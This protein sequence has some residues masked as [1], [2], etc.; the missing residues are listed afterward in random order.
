MDGWRDPL[1]AL[2]AYETWLARQPLSS[3]TRG[4]YVRWVRLFCGWLADGAD[5]RALGADPLVDLAARDYAAR[6]FKRFLKSE[7]ALGPASVNL[8][9][10]AVDHLY[11]Q[12]GLGRANVRREALPVAAPRALSRDE[13]RALLRAAERAGARDRAL[14]VLMLF[15]GL[16]IGETVALDSDDVT[17]S[18]RKGVVVIRSGKGDAYREVALNALVRAVLEEWIRE[19]E[20]R[21]PDGELALFLSAKGARIS[22]RAAD[23]AIRRVAGD[24]GLEL[25][26]HVYA[27]PSVMPRSARCRCSG[28]LG[29]RRSRHIHR[30]SRNLR[31]AS[32]GR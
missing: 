15:A 19:R 9:L 16:R 26:A 7:R 12:L 32:G 4:E 5:E 1:Q 29:L 28:R 17:I 10:A 27:D 2:Q 11:R 22:P 6:D 20:G 23:S 30:S 8:A 14:V 24:A 3:R 31:S 21:A 13:Q 18:A 25:S